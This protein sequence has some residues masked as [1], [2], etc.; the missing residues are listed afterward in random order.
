MSVG[1]RTLG[2]FS[3]PLTAAEKAAGGRTIPD[4][5]AKLQKEFFDL[6]GGYK[7]GGC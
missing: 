7:L 5:I 1:K 6:S 2:P 3:G 4:A